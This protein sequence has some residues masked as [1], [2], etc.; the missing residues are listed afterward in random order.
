M[1][2][3]DKIS[4]TKPCKVYH[5]VKPQQSYRRVDCNA[6]LDTKIYE[7]SPVAKCMTCGKTQAKALRANVLAPHMFL[8][9]LTYQTRK[10][11]PIELGYLKFE[12][13]V[14]NVLLNF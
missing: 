14:Q 10:C 11:F 7:D 4:T 5:T 6:K 8:L 13:G 1:A 12:K 3:S 2:Y 9:S